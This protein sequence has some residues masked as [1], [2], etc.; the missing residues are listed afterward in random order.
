MGANRATPAFAHTKLW[1]FAKGGEF[2]IPSKCVDLPIAKP[3]ATTHT[4]SRHTSGGETRC[5]TAVRVATVIT[6]ATLATGVEAQPGRA[7]EGREEPAEQDPPTTD[8][9]VSHGA[10][11]NAAATDPSPRR[12][13][14]PL[15][16]HEPG[17]AGTHLVTRSASTPGDA[18]SPA[19]TLADEITASSA[20][21]SG[22]QKAF[23]RIPSK[24]HSQRDRWAPWFW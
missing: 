9:G 6:A 1:A 3:T 15:D 18:T 7:R 16:R 20:A 11:R 10:L 14:S 23:S 22:G 24:G 17:S 2:N 12:A 4:I 21:F 13:A 8:K 5:L 19:T